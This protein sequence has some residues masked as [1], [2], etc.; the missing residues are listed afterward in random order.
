MTEAMKGPQEMTRSHS[1][2]P[3]LVAAFVAFA[4]IECGSSGPAS[5]QPPFYD[6]PASALAG[7]P[8]T[9][10]RQEP[11]SRAPEGATAYRVL[12]RSTGLKGEPIAV[13]GTI[14]VPAGPRPPGGWPIVAWAH[15]TSGI[16]LICAPSLAVFKFEQIQG[17]R[18]MVRQGYV[19]TATD[20]PGLG[21]PGPHPYLVGVSEG[22]AVLDSARAA[23]N[24]VG[25][26]GASVALWGHSQGGQAVL[27]AG[28]LAHSYAPDLHLVGIAAAAPA[29]DIGTLMQDDEASPGG[30]NLL[31]MTLWSWSRVFG[32][33]L[34]SV[35]DPAAMP[36][37]NKL[38]ASCLESPIDMRP[39]R[40]D[41]MALQ[42]RFLA[43]SNLTAIEPWR[44][45]LAQN[46]IGVLPP[47]IPIFIAQGEKDQT[48]QPQVT[49]DYVGRL[50]A[51]HS[52]VS[53]MIMPDVGHGAAAM[54]SALTAVG[55]IAD[56]FAGAPAPDD[57]PRG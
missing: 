55:W 16:E 12:Y 5:A 31:A 8:G 15:P 33:P 18:T 41:A 50:C 21:T 39:R 3:K 28:L 38:A 42:K 30:K 26:S 47:S 22:R 51:A 35:V 37:I 36:T 24:L 13:S 17:L 48:V 9:L 1:A 44:T 23:E 10:I 40:R 27:Y 43:V 57:C 6:A 11:S 2:L 49:R 56:R 46:T 25:E 32:A 54:K 53:L 45:L 20:Y 7:A 52:R 14:V 19:V 4:T 29:T 34:Q